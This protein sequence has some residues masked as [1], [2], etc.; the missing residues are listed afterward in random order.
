MPQNGSVSFMLPFNDAADA[1]DEQMRALQRALIDGDERHLVLHGAPGS[2]KTSLAV[3]FAERHREHF[4]GGVLVLTCP[5]EIEVRRY[6]AQR[7]D[8][9][10]SGLVLIDEVDRM[11]LQ[12]I[13][14]A[15]GFLASSYPRARVVMTSCGKVLPTPE[16]LAVEMPPLTA[17]QVIGLLRQS[18]PGDPTRLDKL[19]ERLAG[20]ATAVE[21]ISQRLA[22]GMPPERILD[23]VES[24]VLP[25]WRDA[26]GRPL[27]D[28][29]PE[30][31]QLD[32]AVTEV[33]EELIQHLADHP[34]LLYK[35]DP[36]KFEQLAA[37]LYRRRGYEVTLTPASGDGGVDVYVVSRE[38]VGE[39]LWVVQAKR[40]A[41]D[42]KV[43]AG[44][45][46]E[47]VG[48]VNL[49]N[50]S[51]GVLLTTS[52]FEPGAQAIERKLR[53][54]LALKDYLDLQQ[55]LREP[56]ATRPDKPNG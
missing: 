31:R 38:A 1:R 25:V 46:R 24:G 44:V 9:R 16:T 47:L 13:P 21:L 35:L 30:R 23:W 6:A 39:T 27:G 22:A 56:P 29:A 7:L 17:A 19:A 4:S 11:P 33:S 20:N 10:R 52:F 53:Y 14:D 3:A 12:S 26:A 8:P 49:A 54:R 48:T 43:G 15:L 41:P 36:R 28:Q 45:V 2:G 42:H 40:W 55:L 32:I 18:F 5:T 34:E 37:E 50:A 51:A